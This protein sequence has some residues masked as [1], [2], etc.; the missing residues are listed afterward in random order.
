VRRAVLF[1]ALLV[2]VEARADCHC[3]NAATPRI[4]VA[5]ADGGASV[6]ACGDELNRRGGVIEISELQVFRCDRP[7]PLL[8]FDGTETTTVE[9]VGDALRV[10]E[11]SNYPFGEHWKWIKVPV[12]AWLVESRSP[13]DPVAH[14]RLPKPRATR[15]EIRKFLRECRTWI[16]NPQRNYANAEEMD[17][18]LFVAMVA[19]DPGA[20]SLFQ[21]IEALL[22]GGAGEEHA[23]AKY[24]YKIGRKPLTN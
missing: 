3:P 20:R 1:A 9:R 16:A 15:A 4:V 13:G 24:H 17:G 14:P 10:V 7:E 6:A 12:A 23:M 21:Q 18:R 5:P 11:Y 19:G 8:D 22:D 2:V